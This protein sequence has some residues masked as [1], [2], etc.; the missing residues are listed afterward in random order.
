MLSEL[1][2]AILHRNFLPDPGRLAIGL[3]PVKHTVDMNNSCLVP[4]HHTPLANPQP[5]PRRVQATQP[6]DVSMLCIGE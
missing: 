2:E 3:P 1:V 5:E 4:E 6:P